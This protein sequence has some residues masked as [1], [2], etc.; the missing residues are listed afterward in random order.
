LIAYVQ[1]QAPECYHLKGGCKV[2]HTVPKSP[3]GKLVRRIARQRAVRDF[4]TQHH[5]DSDG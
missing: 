2:V 5:Y 4:E 3:S 1:Q